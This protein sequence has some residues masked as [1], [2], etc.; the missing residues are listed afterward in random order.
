MG[1]NRGAS[2]G[3]LL[4]VVIGAVALWRQ[5]QKVILLVLLTPMGLALT[6]A[7]VRLYPYGGQARITQYLAPAICLMAGLGLSTVLRWLPRAI[8]PATALRVATVTLAV[9]GV[10]LLA[11]DLRH[12]YRAIYDH[13]A[14]EFARRFWPEQAEGAELACVQ[15][16][17]GI[18]RRHAA[19]TR[20]A[21]YL[22]NQHIYSPVRK[23]AG[24]PRLTLV[25]QERPLRCVCFDD[26]HLTSPEV[27]AWLESMHE[28][29]NLRRRLD[30]VV[31]TTGLDMKPW[32]DHVVVFEFQPKPASVAG[33][34]ANRVA[35]LPT[36][37]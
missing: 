15:W 4:V 1:G 6:V 26:V 21:L 8:A 27:A 9:A 32:D 24:G 20:T 7:A 18:H 10:V 29:Y 2:S 35:V 12:P 30:L 19:V 13:Q 31:P 25:T 3:T 17:F 23:R 22:C 34:V 5:G 14:R 37:R 28:T 11:E 16:D 33:R 36:A